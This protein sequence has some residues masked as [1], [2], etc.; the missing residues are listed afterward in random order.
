[1]ATQ[2]APPPPPAP[3]VDTALPRV[4]PKPMVISAATPSASGRERYDAMARQ[5]AANP[6]GNFTVQIQILCDPANLGKVMSSG[7]E[8][9]WFVPQP[10]GA[11]SCYRVFWGRY[12]TRDEAQRALAGIP[13]DLRDPS[14]AVKAVPKG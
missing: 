3:V 5:F 8:Q 4:T 6:A 14:A 2:T 12:N 7:G 11:R 9:V 13:G 1:V 10:I